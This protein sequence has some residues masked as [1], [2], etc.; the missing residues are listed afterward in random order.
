MELM[1]VCNS[2]A[3][4]SEVVSDIVKNQNIVETA[5]MG[6]VYVCVRVDIKAAT[7]LPLGFIQTTTT[8]LFTA[9]CPGLSG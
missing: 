2:G 1:H 5:V 9:L 4:L 8:I 7:S 3:E 6:D